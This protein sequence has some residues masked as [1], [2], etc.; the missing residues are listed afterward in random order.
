MGSTLLT[1]LLI[2]LLT[3]FAF[4]L[5]LACFGFAI[6]VT[7]LGFRLSPSADPALTPTAKSVENRHGI[8]KT[9]PKNSRYAGF[10]VGM[11]LL[12]STNG[13]LFSA[14]FLAAKF[15]RLDDP[16]LGAIAGIVIWSA[17]GLAL[18]WASSVAVGK[19]LDA[20][21]STT[22][23]GLRQ[24]L[25]A[26]AAPFQNENNTPLSQEEIVEIVQQEIQ[27]ALSPVALELLPSQPVGD[28]SD[29]LEV[30]D[31]LQRSK[32][33]LEDVNL[34]LKQELELYLRHAS[35]KQLTPE[36]VHYKLNALLEEALEKSS[37]SAKQLNLDQTQLKAVLKKRKAISK[38]QRRQILQA[39][40]TAWQQ[41][42][43]PPEAVFVQEQ[44]EADPS[45]SPEVFQAIT[46]YVTE[47]VRKLD[48]QFLANVEP[49]AMLQKHV[50]E[51]LTF[52]TAATLVVLHQLSQIDWDTLLDRLPLGKF[53]DRPVE[54][55]VGSVRSTAQDLINQPQQ[56]VEDDLIPQTQGLKSQVMQQVEQFEQGLQARTHAVKAQAQERLNNTRKA[57]AAAAWW[58]SMTALTTAVSAAIAGALATGMRVPIF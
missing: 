56:W 52:S 3:A 10:W 46:A 9:G 8:A 25:A 43:T 20:I 58:L 4:H 35:S 24:L 18:T 5:L 2:G 33:A 23:G 27:Q 39:V 53:T 54:Q 14:C 30:D 55:L 21:L 38:Q 19:V 1:A 32:P 31:S 11:G 13:V 49:E 7:A 37:F 36:R 29:R 42:T 40:E 17:Y 34:Q 12:L 48:H 22:T 50:S 51:G 15:S 57:A 41:L 45:S 28:P 44:P 47:A 16:V 26:V 6:G